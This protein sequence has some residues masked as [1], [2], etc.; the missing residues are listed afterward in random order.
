MSDTNSNEVF[1]NLST[2]EWI[3]SAG[4]AW[5]LVVVYLIGNRIQYE[6]FASVLV[7]VAPLSLAVLLA[8]FVRNGGNESAWNKLYPGTVNLAGVVIVAFVALDLLN[9]LAN[10]FSDSGEFYEITLYIAAAVMAGG[11]FQ[12]RQEADS[13]EVTSF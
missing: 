11:L 12:L 3:I 6:Y 1:N 5:I 2:A 9:G 10:D 13:G 4:A 7:L 8:V